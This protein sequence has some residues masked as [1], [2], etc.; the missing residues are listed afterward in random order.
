IKEE[1]SQK[2]IQ[3]KIEYL[4]NNDLF[5]N[6]WYL[7]NNPELKD[8]ISPI[9]SFLEG[10]NKSDPTPTFS[11]EKYR[12]NNKNIPI[13]QNTYMYYLKEGIKNRDITFPST[14][15]NE[16]FTPRIYSQKQIKNI[17]KA[18]NTKISIIIP[19][20][21][22]LSQT[23]ECVE[24]V[25]KYTKVPYEIIIINDNSPDEEVK[26]YLDTLEKQYTQIKVIHNKVNHGFVKNVNIG[27]KNTENDI[28][29]LNSDTK[30]TPKWIQKLIISAYTSSLIG[31]VTPLS[32]AAGAYSVPY[33]GKNNPIP[34]IGLNNM[35]LLVEKISLKINIEVPTGNGFCLYIKRDTIND[36]GLFDAKTFE[37]GYGEENDFC[38]RATKHSW[39]H[40]IDETTYI[41]HEGGGSFNKKKKELEIAHK[42]ILDQLYPDYDRL[43]QKFITHPTYTMIRQ[44]IQ[45]NLKKQENTPAHL[46]NLL[47]IIHEGIGGSL[48]FTNDLIKEVSKHYNCYILLSDSNKITLKKYEKDHFEQIYQWKLENKWNI[49]KFHDKQY[50]TIYFNVIQGLNIDLIHVQHLIK[51][52]YDIVNIA[53]ILKI[54]IV[55]SIHDFYYICPSFNLLDENNKYCNGKCNNNNK[56]CTIPIGAMQ[57]VPILKEYNI[58]WQQENQKLLEM[59]NTIICPS[60]NTKELYLEKYPE[61][62][63]KIRTIPH[64]QEFAKKEE[65]NTKLEKNN[66]KILIPGNI[67]ISKGSYF[68]K[69]LKK[70]DTKNILELHFIGEVHESIHDKKYGIIHGAFKRDDF[71]KLVKEINPSFIGIF[72]IWPETFCYTLSEAWNAQI[73]VITVKLGAI[74]DRVNEN[75]TGYFIDYTNPKKAYN[76]ILEIAKDPSCYNK[77]KE[78]IK[79]IKLKTLKEMDEEYLELYNQLLK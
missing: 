5:D 29:L 24:S 56:Q 58:K 57:N 77:I 47:Y 2:I 78:N 71:N 31:T 72:S 45:K 51:H 46:Y 70:Q 34:S 42:K 32:N 65:I 14:Q 3:E 37:K 21:N 39:T 60:N 4:E 23:K 7:E 17:L 15:Y 9:Q 12:K 66:I 41:Y 55:L 33:I 26:P 61:I 13:N 74:G 53:N 20:Y 6:N 8:N 54:P 67:G 40:V 25:L 30:V 50:E 27:I 62:E 11:L 18:L 16:S 36:T 64:G 44:N 68:I 52:S 38:M 28:I 73:P 10:N 76:Q 59:V 75:I 49:E 48:H 63:N 1:T 35:A 43:I 19:V 69:E 22:A 79:N